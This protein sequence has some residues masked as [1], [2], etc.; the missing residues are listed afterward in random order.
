M[1]EVRAITIAIVAIVI[2][3]AILSFVVGTDKGLRKTLFGNY[4]T[5][6]DGPNS[7]Y[8]IMNGDGSR[9]KIDTGQGILFNL[10]ERVRTLEKGL[11]DGEIKMELEVELIEIN[12]Q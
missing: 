3:I 1:K 10:F 8:L 12:I 4:H 6:F 11:E 2:S 5:G 7:R 9:E